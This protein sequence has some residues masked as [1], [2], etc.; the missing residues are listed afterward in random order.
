MEKKQIEKI[1]TEIIAEKS[2][3]DFV[4]IN[5]KTNL[6]EDLGM[7]SLEKVMVFMEFE[8]TFGISIPDDE[9][10]NAVTVEDCIALVEKYSD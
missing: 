3:Y 6:T 7:D 10:E 9:A 4:T 1:V 8:N 2:E 5:E